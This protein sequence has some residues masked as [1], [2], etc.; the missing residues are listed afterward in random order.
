MLEAVYQDEWILAVDKSAGIHS[1][2]LARGGG[3]DLIALVLGLW[4]DI[5]EVKGRRPGEA[6]ILQRLDR[7]TSGLVL[8]ARDRDCYASLLKLQEEGAFSKEYTA[9][10]Q[11]GRADPRGSRPERGTIGEGGEIESRFRPY[12]P[13]G[14]RVAAMGL[15]LPWPGRVYRSRILS[16][17]AIGVGGVERLVLGL[18]KGFRHQIRL[19]LAWVGLP[20]LGD[21]L[22]RLPEE[23]RPPAGRLMLH[24]SALAFA[25]PK[26]GK[27]LRI[28]C[29]PPAT[30]LGPF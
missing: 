13:R 6:G 1:V 25:H 9:I 16:R 30:F 12:G 7:D 4:P 8:F 17:Q 18:E 10:C 19:H 28:E 5:G 22:Y 3:P 24:A 20:I 29:P 2:P 21:S 11:P 14:A 26:T 23:G 15:G 27:A